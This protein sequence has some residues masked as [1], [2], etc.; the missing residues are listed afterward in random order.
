MKMAPEEIMSEPFVIA[1]DLGLKDL[2]NTAYQHMS[3]ELPEGKVSALC[4]ENNSGK[5]EL[6]LTLAG[7]I[8]PTQGELE[9][10]G[11]E[12]PR[13]RKKIMRLSG[14]GFFEHVNEVQPVLTVQTVT[15]AELN[16]FSKK[17]NKAHTLEYLERMGLSDV[18]SQ[19]VQELDRRVFFRLGIALGMVGD[20]K[21]LVVDD[22]EA[23]LTRHQAISIM[24]YLKSLAEQTGTTIVVGVNEYEVA[25]CADCAVPITV[26]AMAQRAIVEQKI[27]DGRYDLEGEDA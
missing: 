25:R 6:L 15:A 21:L 8:V 7:R 16:L 12:S 24:G 26:G 19:R 18:A 5:T 20:P 4:G 14:L 27:V 1:K 9:V 10:A 3:F 23:D 2:R 11:Y 17:S 22:I 13:E